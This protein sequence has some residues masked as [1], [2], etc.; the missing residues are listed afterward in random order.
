MMSDDLVVKYITLGLLTSLGT[1]AMI[2]SKAVIPKGAGP[3]TVFVDTGGAG[4]ILAHDYSLRRPEV[5]VSVR[6]SLASTARAKAVALRDAVGDGWFNVTIN[7]V[8]YEKI[9][10][11]Q[12]VM[13]LQQDGQGRPKFGFNLTSVHD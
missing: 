6:A 9:V 12:E 13:D 4:P 8:F 7:G 3:Y 1:D 10:A 11:V 5:Q 2:G